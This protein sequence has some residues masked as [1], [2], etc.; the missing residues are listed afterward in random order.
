MAAG[1]GHTQGP[2][3]H[4]GEMSAEGGW[5]P[6]EAPWG[7]LSVRNLA[8]E[9]TSAGEIGVSSCQINVSQCIGRCREEW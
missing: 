8:Q 1:C 5:G 4:I 7:T 2:A 3:S 9:E 6:R